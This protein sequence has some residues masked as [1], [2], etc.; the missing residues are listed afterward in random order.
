MKVNTDM[1]S[2]RR[3]CICQIDKYDIYDC[4]NSSVFS[5]FGSCQRKTGVFLAKI[6][7]KGF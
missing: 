4:V 3:L 5:V 1:W 6:K 2:I 7:K